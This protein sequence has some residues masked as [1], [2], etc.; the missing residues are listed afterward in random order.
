MLTD[1]AYKQWEVEALTM[2]DTLTGT[3]EAARE[4]TGRGI[5]AMRST[6]DQLRAA[7]HHAMQWLPDHRSP[8]ADLDA[9]LMRTART[10]ASLG[11]L[12]EAEASNP[13]GPRWSAIDREM[14][15]LYRALA[16]TIVGI[17]RGS[18]G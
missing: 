17:N 11:A 7:S 6:G 9:L 3:L 12:L 15:G 4:M 8:V 18:T 5:H 16:A 1:V 2:V 14:T 10:Y 13:A